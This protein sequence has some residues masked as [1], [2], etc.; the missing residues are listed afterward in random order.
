M[1]VFLGKAPPPTHLPID[2]RMET[3]VEVNVV[4]SS[5]H[6]KSFL[7]DGTTDACNVEDE[8]I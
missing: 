6:F 8:L 4:L 7:I 2:D 3:E 1:W 5:A